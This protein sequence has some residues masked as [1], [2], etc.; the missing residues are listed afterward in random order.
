MNVVPYKDDLQIGM[1]KKVFMKCFNYP[2][3]NFDEDNKVKYWTIQIDDKAYVVYEYDDEQLYLND[4]VN[5]NDLT[6]HCQ[7][8]SVDDIDLPFKSLNLDDNENVNN[9]FYIPAYIPERDN[10]NNIK[11]I[12]EYV[13]NILTLEKRQQ[14]LSYCNTIQDK[15][16]GDGC[17]LT[18]GSLIDMIITEY[19]KQT[20]KGFEEFHSSESDFRINN[21]DFS[22]KKV[23]GKSTI[24]LNWSKNGDKY[25]K[26]CFTTNIIILNLKDGKWWSTQPRD[27][28]ANVDY[29]KNIDVGLYFID[30]IFCKT[31][32]CVGKNNKTNTLIDSKNLYLM[33]LH[34]VRSSLFIPFPD[35]SKRMNF[36]ILHAFS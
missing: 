13:E 19:F 18:G 21:I 26:K 14:I 33:L 4:N 9:E 30:S 23:K 11:E 32:I 7:S 35:T 28:V 20:I 10:L 27:A 22:F 8:H 24:A 36:N 6:T 29:T 15:L 16:K 12:K 31:N 17:G 3:T 2:H 34:S 1:S 25:N 5:I